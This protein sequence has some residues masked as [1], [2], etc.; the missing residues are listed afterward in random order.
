MRSSILFIEVLRWPVHMGLQLLL[1]LRTR[2]LALLLESPPWLDHP[3]LHNKDCQLGLLACYSVW[4]LWA[5]FTTSIK[6]YLLECDAR[7]VYCLM[8]LA[9]H[10]DISIG[11]DRTVIVLEINPIVALNAVSIHSLI[12]T[13]QLFNLIFSLNQKLI[14]TSSIH[15]YQF[16]LSPRFHIVFYFAYACFYVFLYCQVV[17][18]IEDY[19]FASWL[20]DWCHSGWGCLL[21]FIY[22]DYEVNIIRRSSESTVRNCAI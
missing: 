2:R 6:V 10:I 13:V 7:V 1:K 14:F 5:V 18:A 21:A 17:L 19:S 22:K 3:K 20:C 8:R 12:L 4:S 11:S 15:L 9:I 16:L